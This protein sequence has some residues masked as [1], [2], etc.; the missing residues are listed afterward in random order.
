MFIL[1]S[2]NIGVHLRGVRMPQGCPMT[3][4]LLCRA[5][6]GS[7]EGL[8]W[9][10]SPRQS[11]AGLGVVVSLGTLAAPLDFFPFDP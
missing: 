10:P 11:Y 9:Q 8:G 1:V 2:I 6:I 5:V 3:A 7:P 4:R